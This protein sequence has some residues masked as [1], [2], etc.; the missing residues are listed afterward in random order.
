MNKKF[1]LAEAILAFFIV[2]AFRYGSIEK[3]LPFVSREQVY[4]N[5]IVFHC[6]PD[7]PSIDV[8]SLAR[9]IG[10]LPGVGKYH[11]KIHFKNDSAAFYF[12]QGI[13]LYY[14]FHLVEGMASFAKAQKFDKTSAMLYWAK[15]LAYGPNINDY[16]FTAAPAAFEAAQKALSLSANVTDAEKLLINAIAVRYSADSTNRQSERNKLYSEAMKKA[17]RAFPQNEDIEALYADALMIEHPWNY[18]KH[19]G[20]PQ[21]WTPA[22]LNVLERLLKQDSLHPGANHYYIHMM[23]A[24][25]T[26]GKALP[27]ANRLGNMMPGLSHV[28][29]MPSHI[30][31]RTGYYKKGETVNENAV[32][33][34]NKYLS[35]YPEVRSQ[36]IF[37][38]THNM[39]LQVANAMMLPDYAYSIKTALALRTKVDSLGMLDKPP[40]GTYIQYIYMTP[41]LVLT[42]YEKWNEILHTAYVPARLNYANALWHWARGM[43]FAN[44]HDIV[45]A[46]KELDSVRLQLL[47][48]EMQVIYT[49]FNAPVDAAKVA[50]ELLE[51]S[52]DL[53][54][55]NTPRAITHFQKAVV[56]EDAL[57]Y[58]E[59]RDWPIPARAFLGNA[60]LK[61]NPAAAEK[62]FRQD[63]KIYPYNF[64]AT[65]GLKKS[66]LL[67]RKR[68]IN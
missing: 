15:A 19:D 9:G 60:V 27:C 49:P 50:A 12:N 42:R 30:Y 36:E 54:A 39:H 51:G 65:I 25:G 64:W 40:F 10:P 24:S 11:W 8:D 18:W 3:E 46:K 37:Y 48:P 2:A 21:M 52:I 53:A 44:L 34:Y 33:S 5:R 55:N 13:N 6:T 32:K 31:I 20:L 4:K 47:T 1:L 62:I 35:L 29:H 57:V 22:I 61:K 26:A 43:A 7:W 58:D 59:P 38:L 63:L 45:S 28:V 17:Y 14:A 68:T 16:E 41:E 23:E 56:L 66:L 67:Q